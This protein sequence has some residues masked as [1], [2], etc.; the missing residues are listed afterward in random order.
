MARDEK[1]RPK[2]A[3]HFCELVH[4]LLNTVLMQDFAA[5]WVLEPERRDHIIFKVLEFSELTQWAPFVASMKN[6]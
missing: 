4:Y 3:L 6:A 2:T 5:M 1:G